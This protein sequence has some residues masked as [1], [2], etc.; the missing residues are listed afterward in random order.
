MASEI[1]GQRPCPTIPLNP[2]TA[3]WE[4]LE[5]IRLQ[6]LGLSNKFSRHFNVLRQSY[7]T[8]PSMAM[9][10]DRVALGGLSREYTMNVVNATYGSQPQIPGP[11]RSKT[12]LEGKKANSIAP[13]ATV[14]KPTCGY[15]F[16]RETDNRKIKFG[17]PASDLVK[18]RHF[19]GPQH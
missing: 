12:T 9:K 6:K 19:G 14:G 15:F 1:C 18:W 2:A 7:N 4:R 11:Q 5:D 13:F 3:T 17:I 10:E 8:N 16:S